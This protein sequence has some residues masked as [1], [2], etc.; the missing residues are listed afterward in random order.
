MSKIELIQG[1]IFTDHRGVICSLNNFRFNGV[2][3]IY[4]IHHPHKEVV[5]GWHGH[6]FE[7]KWFYCVKGSFTLAL[8]EL[9]DWENPSTDLPVELFHLTEN[10]SKIVCVPE[11]YANCIKAGEDHAVMMVLSGKT[12]PEAY[13]DSWRY[14]CHLWVDWSKY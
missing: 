4:F 10:D 12:V 6:Q 1:E 13:L 9:D 3:R 8:V 7:K 14:D 5:R 2:Q 11:G